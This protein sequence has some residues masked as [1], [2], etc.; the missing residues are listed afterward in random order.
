MRLNYINTYIQM[1][2]KLNLSKIDGCNN[3]NILVVILFCKL[4]ALG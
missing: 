3:V 2:K 4:L 1:S